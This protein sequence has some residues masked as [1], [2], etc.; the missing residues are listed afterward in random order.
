M[1]KQE[2][3]YRGIGNKEVIMDFTEEIIEKLGENILVLTAD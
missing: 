3:E 1:V 2:V